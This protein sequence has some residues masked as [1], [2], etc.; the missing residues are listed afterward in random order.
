MN[1]ATA[2]TPPSTRPAALRRSAPAATRRRCRPMPPRFQFPSLSGLVEYNKE[3][4]AIESIAMPIA[5]INCLMQRALDTASG[6]PNIKYV[7]TSERTLTRQ[8]KDALVKHLEESGPGEE[9]SGSVLFIYNTDIKVHKLDNELGDIHSKIPL[10]D[11]TRQIAGVFGVP[12]PLLGLGSADA[13]K[14]ASNYG[15]SRLSFWQ[16]TVVPC[17][18][19]PIAAGMT[20]AIC[21]PGAR[22][23]FDLDSIPALWEGRAALGERLSKVNFLITNEKRAILGFE[24]TDQIPAVPLAPASSSADRADDAVDVGTTTKTAA[25]GGGADVVAIHGRALQ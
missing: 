9:N 2:R 13:A 19:S 8:Q 17:Y 10:D 21:P 18:L 5:I 15:E 16:D 1:T 12:I 7:I 23:S 24:P 20:Q 22:V 6:H 3:P 4:A 25:T 14:Y 11:M